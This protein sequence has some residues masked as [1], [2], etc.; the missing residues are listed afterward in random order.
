MTSKYFQHLFKKQ[1]EKDIWGVKELLLSKV[2]MKY[3]KMSSKVL[4][5]WWSLNFNYLLNFAMFFYKVS[6]FVNV[7]ALVNTM[8]MV[9]SK[10]STFESNK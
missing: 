10:M 7:L 3:F 6:N 9:G 2:R 8:M 4:Y 1:I 5:D